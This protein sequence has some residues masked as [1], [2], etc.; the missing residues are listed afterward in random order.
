MKNVHVIFFIAALIINTLAGLM[1]DWY[2]SFHWMLTDGILIANFVVSM[3]YFSKKGPDAFKI[4]SGLPLFLGTVL[5]FI[6][7]CFSKQELKNNYLLFFIIA[8]FIGQ[9]VIVFSLGAVAHLGNEEAKRTRIA[10]TPDPAN[11]KADPDGF[12]AGHLKDND[13]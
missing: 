10:D 13:K 4:V 2:S 1:F 5:M 6:L 9:T 7:A 8:I 12:E 3:L 11:V